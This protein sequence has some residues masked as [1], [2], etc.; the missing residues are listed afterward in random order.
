MIHM[1]AGTAIAIFNPKH[2]PAD[3]GTKCVKAKKPEKFTSKGEEVSIDPVFGTVTI[4]NHDLHL[5]ATLY[6]TSLYLK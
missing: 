3:I 2:N 4:V 5:R 6:R 1:S